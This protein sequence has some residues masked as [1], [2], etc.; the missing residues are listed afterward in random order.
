M[1]TVAAD[2][3]KTTFREKDG[4]R[5]FYGQCYYCKETELACGKY[6]KIFTK[7]YDAIFWPQV[8][9]LKSQSLKLTNFLINIYELILCLMYTWIQA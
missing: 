8:F 6:L 5:C 3:L 7:Y 1:D 9:L 2:R 4:N